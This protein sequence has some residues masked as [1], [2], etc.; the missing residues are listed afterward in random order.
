M[1]G[2]KGAQAHLHVGIYLQSNVLSIAAFF[3]MMPCQNLG[4][5]LQA[6]AIIELRQKVY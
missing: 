3:L 2:K 4:S 5:E 1:S 6:L